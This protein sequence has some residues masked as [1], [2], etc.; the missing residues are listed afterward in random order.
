MAQFQIGAV[1]GISGSKQYMN[2]LKKLTQYT[3]EFAAENEALTSSFKDGLRSLTDVSKQRKILSERIQ[4]TANVL[5]REREELEKLNAKKREGA[6]LTQEESVRFSAIQTDINKT[7]AELNR[8]NQEMDDLP[9]NSFLGNLDLIKEN[10]KNNKSEL[11][12]WGDL[13][14]DLGGKLT[15]S[16]T[17]PLVGVATA[18]VK[19]AADFESAF[20]GV[21]KT[22][23]E[24]VDQNGNVI[25]SYEQL[26]KELRKIPLE[27]ASSY[28][29]VMAVAEAAGQLGV[30]ADEVAN[31]TKNIIMLGDSTN[32]SAQEGAVSIAQFMNIMG[33][34]TKTVDR[35]G[36]ALVALGNNTATDEASILALATRLASAGKSIGLTTADVLG[37]S[38]AMSAVGVTAEA[39][40]TAMSTT[41]QKITM[42]IA[43]GSEDVEKFAQITGMSAEQFS[44]MWRTKPI[45]ALQALLVGMGNLEGGGEELITLLDE[46]GWSGIRQSDLIR[47]LSLDYDGVTKAVELANKAYG[48]N[49]ALSDEAS[50]RYED[51]N[52]KVSQLKESAKQFGA[53]I[54]V[55]LMNMI[56]PLIEKLTVFFQKLSNWWTG[57]DQGTKNLILTISGLVAIAGPVLAIAGKVLVFIASAKTVIMTLGGV[58]AALASPIGLAIAAAVLAIG[59]LI[60]NW[61]TVKEFFG[62]LSA[63]F[64]LFKILIA[65][66][67]K[68]MWENIK[69]FGANLLSGVL[70]VVEFVTAQF[71]LF[72]GSTLPNFV[73]NVVNGFNNMKSQIG[74][75]IS[76]IASNI[77]NTFVD[78]VSSAWN[79]GKDLIGNIISGI[80]SKISSLVDSVRNVA[81]TIW[82]YLHFSEPEKGA[83]SDFHTWMPDMMK[84][85]AQGIDDNAYLVDNAISRVA[86][87]LTSPNQI[88]YG[89][90]VINLNVPQGTNGQQLVNEIE[91]ELANRT[92]RRRAV[93]G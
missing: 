4:A 71:I 51:F 59:T 11:K 41:I 49:T 13:L 5:N 36:S 26:E 58:I 12:Q 70:R 6:A 74:G 42:S 10:I 52:S 27:T 55:D 65:E 73:K 17:L 75:T 82:S 92:I 29:T 18:G 84:G 1:I 22:V 21:R 91:D 14:S 76:N 23:D 68:T 7:T 64:E 31:F 79:W 47:R 67:L 39:G 88:N 28:E 8:L 57:L 38:A 19:I 86:E 77:R 32:V 80:K 34:S 30:K 35:F 44:E 63:Y 72:F 54:G 89:G 66:G 33:T 46:L 3:K 53:T 9:A 90:V 60:A 48:E 45:E 62:N 81:S 69:S 56:E 87:S 50:K 2:D 15:K 78:M 40:G 25:Y 43:K 20:T 85:L 93:F 83:L 24:I 61:N 16:V 37:L